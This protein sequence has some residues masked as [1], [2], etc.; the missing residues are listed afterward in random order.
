MAIDASCCFDSR[1]NE[2]RVARRIRF[3]FHGRALLTGVALANDV[4]LLA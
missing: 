4:T 1:L 3:I 2:T